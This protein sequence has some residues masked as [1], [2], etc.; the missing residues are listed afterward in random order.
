MSIGG[1]FGVKKG[2]NLGLFGG[3]SENAILGGPKVARGP[4]QPKTGGGMGPRPKKHKA[5]I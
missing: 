1:V 4:K 3:V 2:V 5:K